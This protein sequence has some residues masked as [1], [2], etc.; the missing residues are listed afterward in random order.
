MLD[1][2]E[3]TLLERRENNGRPSRLALR[4]ETTTGGF[5]TRLTCGAR[6]AIPRER[7]TAEGTVTTSTSPR[8]DDGAPRLAR[9]F[10]SLKR[11]RKVDQRLS[12]LFLPCPVLLQL[13]DAETTAEDS[14]SSICRLIEELVLG[15]A[16]GEMASLWLLSMLVAFGSGLISFVGEIFLS[17]F[18]STP[19]LSFFPT[20][21]E[22]ALC[23]M[24]IDGDLALP[25][26]GEDSSEITSLG[27]VTGVIAS[28]R[29]SLSTLGMANLVSSGTAESAKTS[30]LAT[31]G[32]L[33]ALLTG[34]P[35]SMT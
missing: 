25:A 30:G 19:S 7:T 31:T 4:D 12:R 6:P 20:K 26:R 29:L 17:F 1:L 11:Y 3:L 34:G 10:S 9:R 28:G 27:G 8:R 24:L 32:G 5:G 16:T 2:L 22:V 23:S 13:D 18:S 33:I 15:L 14:A 21:A 35:R